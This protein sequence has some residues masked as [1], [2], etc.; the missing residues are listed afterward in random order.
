MGAPNVLDTAALINWP[1]E[2]LDRGYVVEKQRLEVSRVSPDRMLFLEAANLIWK[3]PT[4]ESINQATKISLDTGDL[5]GLSET[6]LL[7]LALV[8][9][10][11]GH[12]YTDD[13]RIQNV[14]S[15]AGIKWSPV[16]TFGISETWNWE[17]KCGGCGR[18]TSGRGRTRFARESPGECEDCGSELRF[19]KI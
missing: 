7:L 15:S 12:L 10:I 11:K 8:I 17:L 13:Y 2:L 14:C 9:D 1:I 3:S 16:E 4:I 18:V 19:R 6:D 5:D